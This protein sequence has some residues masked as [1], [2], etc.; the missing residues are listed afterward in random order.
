MRSG[1]KYEREF[2]RYAEEKGYHAER[3]AGSG[4]L[5][6]SV[7]DVVLIKDGKPYLVEVKSTNKEIYYISSKPQ[8]RRKIIRLIEVAEKYGA[9][10]LI[11]VWFKRRKWVVVKASKDRQKIVREE[12]SF[13]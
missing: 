9:V 5:S 2:C 4:K 6:F 13:I 7:C 8:S 3:V 12:K 10:P 1:V 11:A